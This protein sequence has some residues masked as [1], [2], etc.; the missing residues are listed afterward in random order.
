MSYTKLSLRRLSHLIDAINE[1]CYV[2]GFNFSE[3]AGRS[4]N[5]TIQLTLHDRVCG[6]CFRAVW[7]ELGLSQNIHYSCKLLILF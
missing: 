7:I 6:S 2:C 1:W 4:S 3:S 5:P